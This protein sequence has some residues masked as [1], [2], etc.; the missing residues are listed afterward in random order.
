MAKP[1]NEFVEHAVFL[2]DA[3]SYIFRA[4]YAVKQGL[5][6]PDGTPTHATHGFMQMTHTLF[7]QHHP[8]HCVFVW[9][10]KEKGVRHDVYPLYKAN[11]QIPPEDLGIQIDNVKKII[12]QLGYRQM[13]LIGYEADDI[14]ATLIHQNPTTDFIVV[15]GDKD[16]LQLVG[17]HV[18]CLDTMKNK[19]SNVDEAHE[20]FGVPPEQISLVQALS[21]DSV[22]NV[23]GAPGIGPKTATELVQHFGSLD[24]IID[25]AILRAQS[26]ETKYQDPLKGKR[27]Q[28][29]S[30][31]VEK[32]RIS[33]KLVDLIRDVP[34]DVSPES[35]VQLERRDNELMQTLQSLGFAKLLEKYG[36]TSSASTAFQNAL[37]QQIEN[38]LFKTTCIENYQQLKT[39][40]SSHQNSVD[41][42]LDTETFSLERMKQD[43]LVGISFAFSEDEGFYLPLRHEGGGDL[44]IHECLELLQGFLNQRAQSGLPVILQ[45]AKFDRHILASDGFKWP[46]DL[47]VEDT[48]LESFVIDPSEKHGMDAL[49]IKYLDGYKT[50]SFSDLV[51]KDSNFSQVPLKQATFY[52]A[53]DAVVTLKLHKVL[54]KKLKDAMTDRV[55]SELD[56]PLIDVLFKMERAGI[57][58]DVDILR[59]L[60]L[61]LKNELLDLENQAHRILKDYN[62]EFSEEGINFSSPKQMAQVLYEQLKL[63]ILKKGKTGP[64]TDVTV[65]E[66]LALTHPFP[67]ILLEIRELTKLLSTYI[68]SLPDLIHPVTK[69]LHTDFSQIIAAT[70]RLASSNP[71][72]QNIPIRT[73]RGRKIRD[74]F[75]VRDGFSLIGIDYSQIELRILAHVSQDIELLKAFREGADIHR[76][77]AALILEKPENQITDDERRIAKAINF[78]IIYGQTAFGLSKQLKIPK[79][80]AQRF[81]DQYNR[82]YVGIQ[83]YADKAIEDA[84][85]TGWS[86]TLTGRR[87]LIADI[88]AKNFMLR[89]F[90]ERVAVNTP[91]QGTAADLMKAAMIRAQSIIDT[92]FDQAKMVLQVHDELLFEVPESQAET[93]LEVMKAEMERPDL[94]KAL[95]VE[96]FAVIMKVEGSIGKNWGEI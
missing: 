43:N 70:G 55:Y 39:I 24:K 14:I 40:L 44:D 81:I 72:L 19:W 83:K 50:L 20:K 56:R 25:E 59:K 42:A 78:G 71:N 18:W 66:E 36:L 8:K 79:G 92:Q 85:K 96:P 52:A 38:S 49:A 47:M 60:S 3:Y 53:E 10:T 77:T 45:N 15:T 23:P 87:R 86:V 68:D 84:Q 88:H 31:N 22:D 62:C 74:A 95:G 5:T 17:D 94:L 69:R 28:S 26:P 11:R 58:L 65:L 13:S 57:A 93:F 4:Y 37:E 33:K 27:I 91:I 16:L 41:M 30:E 12:D 63:P 1:T 75:V 80:D 2:I 35:L 51:A 90:A 7:D 82:T 46:N 34:L 54:S 64:S 9:D 6:A 48:M 89:Q 76:R 21:G 32:V 29:I 73:Q 61:E 67:Q